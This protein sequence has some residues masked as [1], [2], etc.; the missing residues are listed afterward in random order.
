MAWK[1]RRS[2]IGDLAEGLAKAGAI[3]FGTFTLPDSRE[4]SYYIN[5]R[6]ILNYPGLYNLA[7][8]SMSRLVAAK[9]PKASAICGVPISGLTLAAPVALLLK[10]PLVY[11][12][13]SRQGSGRVVEGEVRPGW[14]V[15]VVDDLSTTG[16][17]ILASARAVQEEGG[18]VT[19]AVV[20]IDRME[21][22]REK[23]SKEGIVLHCMTDVM[24]LADTLFSME[25]IGE[26]D[27]KA[28]TKS[29]GGRQ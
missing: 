1:T 8:D 28:I 27:L 6:G 4:S 15:V 2:Q 17:T 19:D 9:A 25:L 21:G 7:V 24:E 12:R 16:K 18:E 10:K 11:A 23:L 26:R 20:L 3:Q 5:L 13:S 14:K 22:A 29:V